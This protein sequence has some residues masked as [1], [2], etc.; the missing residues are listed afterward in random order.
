M[1]AAEGIIGGVIFVAYWSS[2]APDELSQKLRLTWLCL[3]FSKLAIFNIAN[4]A[5]KLALNLKRLMRL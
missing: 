2:D 3:I 1:V 5:K 4:H